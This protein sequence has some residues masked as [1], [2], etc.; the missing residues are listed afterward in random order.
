M[1]KDLITFPSFQ[2]KEIRRKERVREEKNKKLIYNL[3][4]TAS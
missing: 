1:D 2:M 4:S 3:T